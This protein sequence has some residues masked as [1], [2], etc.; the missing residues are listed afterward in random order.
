MIGVEGTVA[1]FW[2]EIR[3]NGRVLDKQIERQHIP[4]AGLLPSIKNYILHFCEDRGTTVT[5]EVLISLQY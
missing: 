4:N 3:R 5:Q 1:S 2:R